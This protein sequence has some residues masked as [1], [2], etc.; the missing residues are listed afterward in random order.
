MF[1][2][3]INALTLFENYINYVFKEYKNVCLI[4]YL[5]N[6]LI[7]LNNIKDHIKHVKLILKKFI[8][9]KL[10]A[11]LEKCRFHLKEVNYLSYLIKSFEIWIKLA[12]IKAILKWSKSKTL[13]QIQMFIHFAN[14]Y[15]RFI[16]KFNSIT[17][18]L[19]NLLKRKKNYFDLR[20]K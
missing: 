20:T 13:R 9:Y 4:I 1:F 15:R 16:K 18:E 11:K 5:N 7:F 17:F 12:R 8:K 3:L 6:I 19:T 10:Y 14:F 2:E